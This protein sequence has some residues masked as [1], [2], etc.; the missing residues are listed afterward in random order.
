MRLNKITNPI[1]FE[2]LK[3]QL[4]NKK[5]IIKISKEI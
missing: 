5:N 3:L 4:I 2:L 1:Y